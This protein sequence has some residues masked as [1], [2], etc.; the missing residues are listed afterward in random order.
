[1]SNL[2]SIVEEELSLP[3]LKDATA[4]EAFSAL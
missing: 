3:S 2:T 4:K 1:M